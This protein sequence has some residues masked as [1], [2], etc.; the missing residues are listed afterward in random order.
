MSQAKHTC[1][2]GLQWGDE[3][4][5]KVVDVLMEQH[6][7]VT[8]YAGG[9]NAGHTIVVGDNKFALHQVPSGIIREDVT[10]V[11]GCGMVIDPAILLSELSALADRKIS[12]T[13]RLWLSARAH[14]V[15]PY[16]RGEDSFAEQ[17][18]TG[19]AKLGT[20]SRGIGPCY[21]DKVSRR[22]GIRVCDLF[23]P[24]YLRSMLTD[25]VAY[26]NACFATLFD[27]RELLDADRICDEYLAFAEQLAPYVTDT[28]TLL[29]DLMGD[30][31]RV[32]FEGA[33]GFMLDLDHGTYPYVTSSSVGSG[34][35]SS[36][37]GVP[38]HAISSV[39]GVLKAY[40]TRVGEGPFPTEQRGELGDLI[41]ERGHEYGTTTGRPRRCGWFDAVAVRY[42]TRTT[43]PTGLA[44]LHLDTLS[45]I[46]DLKICVGYKLGGEFI[47]QFPPSAREL[48]QI[49]PVYETM[50]GWD[51]DLTACRSYEEL[52]EAAKAYL[53][54][55]ET[56]VGAPVAIIG[57]GPDRAQTI[58][59]P[60]ASAE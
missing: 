19:S 33:Q 9:A 22:R 30:G 34:G 46:G 29:H 56:R 35:V 1:V 58:M 6:S 50:P 28:T 47:R 48:E 14:L 12:A 53:N 7:V 43:G 25:I 16:H 44:V 13:G 32:L 24:D 4:K 18:A 21:S 40:S 60:A 59:A 11:L 3:G 55:I 15:L 51:E 31:Q 36:G 38:P 2:F 57:V 49:E 26:K 42:A 27:Q 39:I 8:R 10:C 37:A 20:T 52:P 17:A 23:E 54:A 41:R 45:G 5:G